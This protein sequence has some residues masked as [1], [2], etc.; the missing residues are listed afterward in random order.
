MGSPVQGFGEASQFGLGPTDTFAV[1]SESAPARRPRK[2]L[3]TSMVALIVLAIAGSVIAVMSGGKSAEAAVIDSVN[4]TM[5]DRT[6]HITMNMSVHT[7]AGTV[8]GTGTGGIDFSG[9]AMQMQITAGTADQ[10]VTVQ[11]VY[12]GGLIYENVPGI[13]QVVPGKSWVSIDLSS[14]GAS[15]GQSTASLGTT[16]NPAAMLRLLTQ[17]G[18]TVVPLGSS[19]IDGTSV[20]GYSVTLNSAAIKNQIA[21]AKLPSWMTAA[22]S[23]VDIGDTTVDVYVDGSGLLRRTTISLTETVGSSGKTTVDES[24][25]FS[26]YGSPVTVSAPPSDQVVTF[27]QF[28]EAAAAAAPAA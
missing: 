12:L 18:N 26:D 11:A 6:A 9:N 7:P 24:L 2:R 14:L 22:L 8:T 3:V 20:Q 1:G 13:D 10:Q 19:S 28:L 15:T 16:D 27:Q 4:S 23:H 5:A 21:N 17:Q 25:D